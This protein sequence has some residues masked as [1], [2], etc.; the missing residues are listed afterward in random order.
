MTSSAAP[1]WKVLVVDG[2]PHESPVLSETYFLEAALRLAP[3][4]ETFH[5]TPYDP[6]V[7]AGD[8]SA[9]LPDFEDFDL[10]ILANVAEEMKHDTRQF[11]RR[12]RTWFRAVDDAVWV[13]PVG[14][15]AAAAERVAPFL[16]A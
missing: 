4:G 2:Q 6:T 12:Q 9:A 13:D 11:A 5:N 3:S 14:E 16:D 8:G 7:V 1:P 15:A 10:V